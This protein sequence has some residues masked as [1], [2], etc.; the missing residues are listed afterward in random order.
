VIRVCCRPLPETRTQNSAAAWTAECEVD[1][2]RFEAKSRHG[3]P[4]ELARHLIAAGLPHEP[5]EIHYEGLAGV[6]RF[7]SFHALAGWTY[8]EGSATLLR[9]VPF[10]EFGEP[11]EGVETMSPGGP[12]CV[13]SATA[14][15]LEGR[16]GDR[17]VSS[18]SAEAVKS[19]P[20]PG[21]ATPRCVL[22]GRRFRPRRPWATFCS[23]RCRV[24]AHRRRKLDGIGEIPTAEA[25]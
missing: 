6:M 5:L 8:S 23:A 18:G 7:P 25:A 11:S 17:P 24:A 22:C 1:G 21:R 20:I 4:N 14:G 12:G 9:R 10:R 2:R 15:S 13:T 16:P 19:A 3:A